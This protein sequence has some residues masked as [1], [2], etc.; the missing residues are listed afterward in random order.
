MSEKR[1]AKEYSAYE[2]KLQE[3][4]WKCFISEFSKIIIFFVVFMLLN[5]TREYIVALVCLMVLRNHGGGLHCKHYLSC[6]LVS[7]A[8]LCGSILLGTYITPP[9]FFIYT[10]TLL[11]TIIGY[12]LVP[13]TSSNRPEAT[14]EQIRKSKRNTVI[15]ILLF[16]VLICVCPYNTYLNIS[17]WTVIL[18]ILQLLVAHFTKEVKKH[19]RIRI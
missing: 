18:H 7:F 13:I 5:L 8:F 9:Q 16:F 3:Y 19:A 6:L 1:V 2:K 15:I 11:C 17:F 4:Y 10:A 14:F 12:Y